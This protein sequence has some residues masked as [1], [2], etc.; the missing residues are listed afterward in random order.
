MPTQVEAEADTPRRYSAWYLIEVR[1]SHLSA[2]HVCIAAVSAS[3]AVVADLNGYYYTSTLLTKFRWLRPPTK[4]SRPGPA[5]C[6]RALTVLPPTRPEPPTTMTLL[7]LSYP[8]AP[9]PSSPLARN[10][11]GVL[12]QRNRCPCLLISLPLLLLLRNK[13]EDKQR[14]PLVG[15]HGEL[16]WIVA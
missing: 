7:S 14:T 9:P 10:A 6:R 3:T 1:Q 8:R 13:F 16:S 5:S 4:S 12:R 15:T 11:L 2:E